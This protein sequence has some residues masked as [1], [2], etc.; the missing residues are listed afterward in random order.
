MGFT[1][2]LAKAGFIEKT[3]TAK[4][5][6]PVQSVVPKL[7]SVITGSA[8]TVNNVVVSSPSPSVSPDEMKKFIEHFD[9]LFKQANLPGPDYF[10]F[11]KMCQ[12]MASLPEEPRF[13][14]AFTGLQVQGLSK[15]KLIQSAN[16]YIKVVDEDAQKFST[17]LDSKLLAEV[18][19]KRTEAEQKKQ[20]LQNKVN[21]IAQ[22]QSELERDTVEI[23]KITSEADEKER[24]ANEKSVTYRAACDAVKSLI[25]T[26]L[27][28]IST[29]IK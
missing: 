14:A 21:M 29:Y 2:L 7:T 19:V 25:Q 15:E 23:E 26:D 1:D 5:E 13:T 8:A 16:H 4:E 12:A 24:K 20:S 3:E 11:S 10:E 28:K 22:L 27:S 6:K 9:D 18:K 17:T